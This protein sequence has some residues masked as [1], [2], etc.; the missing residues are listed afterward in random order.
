MA[1]AGAA[2]FLIVGYFVYARFL[3]PPPHRAFNEMQK[4]PAGPYMY[5][6]SPANLGHTF[7]I[8]KYEVTFG[9]YLNFLRAVSAAGTDAAWR[10]PAQQGEKDHQPSDWLNIFQAI[11]YHQPYGHELITLDFPVFNV[12]WYD[13]QAYAKWAGKRL[14]TDEEWEKAA[15]GPK[16]NLFPWGTLFRPA[17]NT[18][19]FAEGASGD[20]PS[21]TH[22]VVDANPGDRSPY[23]VMDMAGNVSEWTATIVDSTKISGQKVGV[24]RGANFLTHTLEHEE[25]TFRDTDYA[26]GSR[27]VWLG[28]R[29]ASDTPPATK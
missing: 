1:A 19:I 4:V 27:E 23:G 17:A 12:D 10:D 7:Y 29:C 14:P 18:A 5:Q 3:A 22:Q 8:D 11:K 16:G 20:R 21:R 2:L 6:G 9:Q 28:F 15:R 24:I 26:L 13:A 25:L